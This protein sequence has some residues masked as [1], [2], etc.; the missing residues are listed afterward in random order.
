MAGAEP[1][2]VL[3]CVRFHLGGFWIAH[4]ALPP[5]DVVIHVA[6]IVLRYTNGVSVVTPGRVASGIYFIPRFANDGPSGAIV[7]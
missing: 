3:P 7:C 5:S 6:R 2:C 1:Q 4:Y